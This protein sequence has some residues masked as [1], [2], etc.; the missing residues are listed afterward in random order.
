MGFGVL[1][2]LVCPYG[3]AVGT[4]SGCCG[5]F[6]WV[7]PPHPILTGTPWA[8]R[9][10]GFMRVTSWCSRSGWLSNSSGVSFFIT[11]SRCSAAN[12]GTPYHVFG[13]PLRIK[14]G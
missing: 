9:V 1:W 7:P 5:C 13:S 3:G 8:M 11:S 10:L 12:D 14:R 2:V 6:M 4:G